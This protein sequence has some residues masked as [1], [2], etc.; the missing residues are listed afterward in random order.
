V[1]G[2]FSECFG[3]HARPFHSAIT[4]LEGGPHRFSTV[5]VGGRSSAEHNAAQIAAYL[6]EHHSD[7]D[8][9]L[10]MIGYSKGTTDILQFLVDYPAH[11][12]AVDA[13]VSIAGAVYGSP[14]A[15]F[16]DGPYHLLFSHLPMNL[17]GKGDNGVVHSLRTD[18]RSQWLE[19]NA[20]PGNIKYYSMAAFTT[21]D[22][23]A[24]ALVP[25][26]EM[27]LDHGDRNDGQ[28]LPADAIIPGSTVLGYLNADHWAVAMEIEKELEFWAHREFTPAFPHA[29]LLQAILDQ[30][31]ADLAPSRAT[32]ARPGRET[33]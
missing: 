3:E 26:W 24:R 8:R 22:R 21:R 10:I 13:V 33:E 4:E 7:A 28:L 16:F 32:V 20:L 15:D 27:L 12:E 14:L 6:E 9:E 30:V 25:S 2:A 31:G 11:A 1:T 29:A 19:D 18:L 23:L 17:C 5:V